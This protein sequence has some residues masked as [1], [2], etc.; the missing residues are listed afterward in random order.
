MLYQEKSI[1][2][3]KMF[4]RKYNWSV[5]KGNINGD[6]FSTIWTKWRDQETMTKTKTSSLFGTQNVGKD[7]F[8]RS[9]NSLFG[10][11]KSETVNQSQM[12]NVEEVKDTKKKTDNRKE[13]SDEEEIITTGTPLKPK[14]DERTENE[15]LIAKL[16]KQW[17]VKDTWNFDKL[18]EWFNCKGS[19]LIGTITVCVYW[20]IAIWKE[21]FPQHIAQ[22]E[23]KI[24]SM[25]Q[26]NS[27]LLKNRPLNDVLEIVS[28]VS[29]DENL[30]WKDHGNESD[31]FCIDWQWLIW[32]EWV[33][34]VHKTHKK[35]MYEDKMKEILS[36]VRDTI[37]ELEKTQ[38]MLEKYNG[39]VEYM[40]KYHVDNYVAIYDQLL[41]K[42]NTEQE[43][44]SNAISDKCD[45]IEQDL[46]TRITNQI[47]IKTVMK[48]ILDA[49]QIENL[50]KLEKLLDISKNYLEESNSWWE[51]I[52]A[53]AVSQNL[54]VEFAS[55]TATVE[56]IAE[57]SISHE[58]RLIIKEDNIQKSLE[59][60]LKIRENSENNLKY[61]V[62][63][64]V[65]KQKNLENNLYVSI[66]QSKN[67]HKWKI[68]QILIADEPI[69]TDLNLWFAEIVYASE[70]E[71]RDKIELVF[72]FT[73]VIE[74][75]YNQNEIK[76]AIKGIIKEAEKN[77][78]LIV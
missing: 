42:L 60:N 56:F 22:W 39:D 6:L 8:A 20:N 45:S 24:P 70:K 10:G 55:R 68:D 67:I 9:S 59:A 19:M 40:R 16:I 71:K 7:L 69:Q 41:I 58:Q 76:N 66:E 32:D 2:K 61:D 53:K 64:M 33:W 12:K 29:V 15:N 77:V 14:N 27:K 72:K 30:K 36:E 13:E 63:L 23:I 31:L 65:P 74:N 54:I 17:D 46:N 52:I 51:S 3:N 62:L 50:P 21:W 5:W 11:A 26:Y 38:K 34:S 49:N 57:N 47:D 35:W 28:K 4:G 48:N 73:I 43:L 75:D 18:K 25:S 78:K 37:N 44:Y 1:E